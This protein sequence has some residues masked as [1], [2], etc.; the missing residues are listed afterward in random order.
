M[1][2]AAAIRQ[3]GPSALPAGAVV[4]ETFDCAL[5]ILGEHRARLDEG[6]ALLLEKE[7]CTPAELPWL[8]ER[9]LPPR[10]P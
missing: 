8:S 3:L 4:E 10:N 6:A 9:L 5:R 7:T 2:I 1:G